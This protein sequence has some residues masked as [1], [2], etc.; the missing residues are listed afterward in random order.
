ML[1]GV[2]Y[3]LIPANFKSDLM[4]SIKSLQTLKYLTVELQCSRTAK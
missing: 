4:T 2:C 1:A 3:K